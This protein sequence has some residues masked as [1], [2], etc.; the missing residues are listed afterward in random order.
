M[1]SVS[2]FDFALANNIEKGFV[3]MI[4]DET[5]SKQD[6]G[7]ISN[8][9]KIELQKISE[10]LYDVNIKAF[11]TGSITIRG[12][13]LPETEWRKKKWKYILLYLFI[14]S[15]KELTKDK[16]IDIFYPDYSLENS[17]NIFHQV[18]S[19]FRSLIKAEINAEQSGANLNKPKSG[20]TGSL[21]LISPLVTYE[22]KVVKL[23]KN[24]NFKIDTN[25]FEKINSAYIL[26]KHSE[27]KIEYAKS[28]ISIYKGEFLEGLYDHW[29]EELRNKYKTDFI[30]LSEG[31]IELLYNNKRYDEILYYSEKLL[32]YDKMNEKAFEYVIKTYIFQNK[33]NLA[34][35]KYY[36]MQKLYKSEL[37]DYNNPLNEKLK[38]LLK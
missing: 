6:T 21:A 30:N 33:L 18:I 12:K 20:K 35:E 1:D 24:F 32:K 22:D 28:A 4:I 3:K 38:S 10:K 36:Y 37:G 13:L 7:W 29:C 5:I 31:L 34:R 23:N 25:E 16:L 19:K 2:L 11:G 15:N 8:K 27:R 26:A 14:S 9:T 17:D